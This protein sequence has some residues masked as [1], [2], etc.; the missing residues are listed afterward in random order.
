MV[1]FENTFSLNTQIGGALYSTY[2]FGTATGNLLQNGVS[3]SSALTQAARYGSSFDSFN[4]NVLA[5]ANGVQQSINP[6][7]IQVYTPPTTVNAQADPIPTESAPL[8]STLC[9]EA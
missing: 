5:A 2:R 7:P 9:W 1:G 3:S 8:P 4:S 6:S